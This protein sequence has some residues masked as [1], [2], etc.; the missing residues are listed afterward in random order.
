MR[1]EM[2][3]KEEASGRESSA[4]SKASATLYVGCSRSTRHDLLEVV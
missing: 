3:R 1:K 4:G 2:A